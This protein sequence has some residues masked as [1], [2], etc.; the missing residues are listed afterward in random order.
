MS[1]AIA[2]TWRILFLS[3]T[4]PSCRSARGCR[5]SRRAGFSAERRAFA[6]AGHQAGGAGAGGR[7]AVS[8]ARSVAT[9]WLFAATLVARC[10]VA[11]DAT[12]EI[13]PPATAPAGTTINVRWTGPNGPGDYI[14][15]VRQGARQADYL[16]YRETGGERKPLNPVSLMLPAQTGAYEV[17]YVRGTPRAVLATVP[18]E[19]TAATATI[20][21]PASLAP[22]S[23]FEVAWQGPNGRGDW[24]TIVAAGAAAR[25]YASYVD[26]LNGRTSDPTGRR[27]ATLVAPKEPGRYELRYVQQGT[28]VIGSQPIDV[29]A[30]GI[31]DPAP[32]VSAASTPAGAS[33]IAGARSSGRTFTEALPAAGGAPVGG[34]AA[35]ATSPT[36]VALHWNCVLGATGYEVFSSMNGGESVKITPTPLNPNCVQDLAQLNPSLRVPGSAAQATY[37]QDF[38]QRGLKPG[39]D[40]TYVVRALYAGGGPADSLPVTVRPL[41]PAPTFRA[42]PTNNL[43]QVTIGWEWSRANILFAKGHVVSRKLAGE[44]AFRQIATV[45]Y[46]PDNFYNDN[47]VPVGTHQYLVE[48][49]DGEKGTPLTVTTGAVRI[50]QAST[51]NIVTVD[52]NFSGVWPGATVRVLSATQATGPFNDVTAE[53]NVSNSNWRAVAAFGSNR[54]YKVAVSYPNG[55]NYEAI[56]QVAVPP[57]SNIGLTAVDAGGGA[58][59][60]WNC[61]PDVA[62]YELLRRTG[63][64]GPFAGVGGYAF[65]VYPTRGQLGGQPTCSYDDTTVPLGNNAEYIVVGFSAKRKGDKPI[66]AAGASVFVKAWR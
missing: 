6:L 5:R 53:G 65:T 24:V 43:G 39:N 36:D 46:S 45:P 15:V 61:E 1:A 48:A 30:A 31:V 16:D 4:R 37:S 64:S 62:R 35:R 50:W 9:A 11:Q 57:A 18:Y 58:R 55:I 66:L 34:V 19:V 29:R 59:L 63:Y 13:T 23:R 41:F 8:R 33:A 54:Y 2:R 47:G 14:T 52:L 25:T 21:G 10:A 38:S 7:P 12:L 32:A 42:G 40:Y 20:E 51:L 22:E 3:A 60:N 44:S 17:R 56:A 27:T 49:I 28:Q 26:A